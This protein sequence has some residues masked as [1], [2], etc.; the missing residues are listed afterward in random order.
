M[1]L[2][3]EQLAA[4]VFQTGLHSLV[5]FVL[6][7]G[8]LK[9]SLERPAA[10]VFQSGLHFPCLLRPRHGEPVTFSS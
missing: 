6:I 7:M 4:L 1:K 8:N 9:L 2:A 3:L 10:L 5:L